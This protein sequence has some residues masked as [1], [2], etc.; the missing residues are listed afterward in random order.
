MDYTSYALWAFVGWL[1]CHS[2]E[3]A[4]MR[5]RMYLSKALSNYLS[6]LTPMLATAN[7]MTPVESQPTVRSQPE[8]ANRPI[9]LVRAAIS[10]M[11]TITGTAITPFKT[12]L[13]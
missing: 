6:Q 8:I 2:P 10:I 1:V 5:R 4:A 11:T 12:A 9:T 3:V 13:Q 7:A